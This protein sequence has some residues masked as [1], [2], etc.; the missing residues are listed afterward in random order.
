MINNKT[1][2]KTIHHDIFYPSS[3]K[4]L[5]SLIE[6]CE[7]EYSAKEK[8]DSKVF[9]LPHA[10][11]EFIL[12]LLINTFTSIKDDF[13][14]V[15]VIA[16]S[17]LKLIDKASPYNIFTT[18]Y[19]AIDTPLGKV[20]FDTAFID[21][22]FKEEMKNVT[23]FEEES[24]FEQLYLLIR[25]YFKGKKVVPIC[26]VIE[27][28]KQSRDFSTLLNNMIDEK[29]LV[30]IS[31]NACSYQKSHSAF[32]RTKDFISALNNGER[33]SQLQRKNII[34]SCGCGII[35]SINKTKMYKNRA[36][37]INL[38]EVEKRV[39]DELVNNTLTKKCVYHISATIR[40]N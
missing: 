12:P 20:E 9:L 37:D 17:H 8:S 19:K 26:A 31:A 4:T 16:P 32:K 24:S 22:H 7:E 6:S 25:H 15:L 1:T 36:W 33:L 39:S 11:Y 13:D 10:S 34:D 14:K 30:L 23:Y 38:I 29:T 5:I 27:N 28:S 3:K 35:D 40:N 18:P 2:D 21:D